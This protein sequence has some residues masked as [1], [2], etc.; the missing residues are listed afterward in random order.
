MA[1]EG[2][3]FRLRLAAAQ[4]AELAAAKPVV[5]PGELIAGDNRLRSLVTAAARPF[6]NH[7]RLELGLVDETV[8]RHP[9]CAGQ[10]REMIAYWTDWLGR[11]ADRLGMTCHA[12]LG[13]ER[14]LDMGV[15]GLRRHVAD[16]RDRTIGDRPE[17]AP[18][19]EALLVTLDGLSRHI[20]AH[21]EAAEAAASCAAAGE[22]RD[23]LEDLAR[24]CRRIAHRAPASFHEAVQLFYIVFSACGHDS[25]GPVDRYL[26]PALERDLAAGAIDVERAQ[27]LV[28]RLWLK[29]AEK[30]A[31][32]AT[33]AGQ[34]RDGTDGTNELSYLCLNAIHRL[35]LLSPRTAVRWHQG[36]DDEFLA[37][38]VD[39]VADGV[40]FPSLI[41]DEA[42]IG[43]AVR[44]GICLEDAREYTFVGCGQ[45]FPH[46]R[47]HGNYEDVV[48]NTPRAI[49][50]ALRSGRDPVT[51]EQAGPVTGEPEDLDS[52]EAFAAAYRQQMDALIVGAIGRVND[53]RHANAGRAFD[54]L[55]SL[56]TESCVERGL[57]WH[58]GG[59]RYCEGM[60]D[61]V[62][63]PT[64]ADALVAVKVGVFERGAVPLPQLV[65]ILDED[66]K[67]EEAL[68]Q[69]FLKGLPK[70]GNGDPEA[71]EMMALETARL[72]ALVRDHRTSFGGPWGIDVIGWSGAVIYGEQTSATPDGRRAG[73][74]VADCAGPGQGR[75]TAGLTQT[76]QSVLRLPHDTAHGPLALSL[77]FPRGGL[78]TVEARRKLQAAI[79]TYFEAGGQQVQISAAGTEEMRAAQDDPDAHGD[80][81]VRVGGF[82]AYFASLDRRWQDDLIARSEMGI[83]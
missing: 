42:L 55:R 64:V 52:F 15:D 24:I 80:L 18:W 20:G 56:L 51:A 38:A 67:G 74:P 32:G 65:R 5:C 79:A 69:Q 54:F 68:R 50:L 83:G 40:G 31:Y 66:W 81:V 77:R 3:D 75:N 10:I 70:Y 43:A 27:E 19:Y 36:T 82:N 6:G 4:A 7:V 11:N 34:L 47:G 16:W 46:G 59:A 39:S 2:E 61:L 30:T 58:E 48:I 44:R 53:R 72:D 33:L 22:R 28:D 73:E 29:L 63:L 78:A 76:L 13:Y 62:G 35:R 8:A 57:D 71:D 45:T 12:S 49:E 21:G 41:N 1:A 26:Y 25:P 17:A 60:V 14:I 23:E 9:E 37:R